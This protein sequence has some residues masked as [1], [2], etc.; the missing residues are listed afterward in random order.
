MQLHT[1]AVQDTVRWSSLELDSGR[2]ISCSTRDSNPCQYCAWLFSRTLYQ[3]N[4]ISCPHS[5]QLFKQR[6]PK[7]HRDVVRGHKTLIRTACPQNRR[8]WRRSMKAATDQALVPTLRESLSGTLL[9]ILP[10]L[11]TPLQR[12]SLSPR[13]CPATRSAPSE[14][15]GY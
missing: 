6:G 11:V 10:E 7:R 5:S 2:K 4:Y 12:Y 1:G 15:F 3:Q 14:R 13:S 9:Q 8:S